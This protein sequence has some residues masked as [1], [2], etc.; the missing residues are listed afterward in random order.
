MSSQRPHPSRPGFTLIELLVVI[1]IIGVLI[2]LL[3]PAVQAAREAARRAQCTNNL[4]Q[5][6]IALHNY[7]GAVGSFP[8][9]RIYGPTLPNVP[10][11]H[12]YWPPN[13]QLLPYLEQANMLNSLNMNLALY[14]GPADGY[15]PYPQN[16]TALQT[17][18][19]VF[20]CPSDHGRQIIVNWQ[21]SNYVASFGSGLNGG[22]P[23]TQTGWSPDGPFYRNSATSF[24]D[25][26]DGTSNTAAFSESLLGLGTGLPA[27][28]PPAQVDPRRYYIHNIDYSADESTPFTDA[29]CALTTGS[30]FGDRNGT[31][32]EGDYCYIA[33]NHYYAP[34]SKSLDCIR[35]YQAG[36]KAAR[37]LHPGGVNVLFLDGHTQFVKD[38]VAVATWRALGTRAGGEVV[39]S[40]AY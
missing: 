35:S 39:S 34:N 31:W 9:G 29:D 26:T 4:K 2:A 40:D 28:T 12:A 14:G 25:V 20:L 11:A 1:A 3:L 37:S 8:P 38:A 22:I 19:A 32:A 6:G 10:L 5:I 16:V 33:Y 30:Y 15:A 13:A 23:Y 21:P 27:T 36:R 24:R 17:Q 18:V 7:A